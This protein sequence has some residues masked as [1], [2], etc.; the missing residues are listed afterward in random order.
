MSTRRMIEGEDL[1][2][3]SAANA[4][5]SRLAD[6]FASLREILRRRYL[7]MLAVTAI[8]F[9]LAIA[10]LLQLTPQYVAVAKLRID[11]SRN[12]VG[13]AREA[14]SGLS[15]EAIETEVT[16]LASPEIAREVTKRLGLVDDPA[17]RPKVKDG[18]PAPYG[19]QLLNLVSSDV[20]RGLDVR[21]EKLTYVIAVGYQAKD[22]TTAARIANAFAQTY[23]DTR[24]GGNTSTAQRQVEWFNKQIETLGA[25]ARGADAQ[26]AQY[27][28]QAGIVQGGA[29]GTITDQQVAPLSS[30]LAE[31]QSSAAEARAKLV[32]A[33]RQVRSGGLDAVADVRVS[34]VIADLRRQLAEVTRN[35]G[36]ITSRYGDRHPET[37]KV[38]QQVA[39]LNSQIQDEANRTLSSL[40][41]E[42]DAA[43]AR[44]A[45]LQSSLGSLK[46]QQAVN[47]RAA[48]IAEGME[49]E[50]A[51]KHT[52]YDKM[53]QMRLEALQASRNNIGNA[54]L[55]DSATPPRYPSAP[56]KRVLAALALVAALGMGIAVIAAQELLTSGMRTID[57]LESRLKLPVLG[58]LPRLA[59]RRGRGSPADTLITQ[60][61][62]LYGEALR[63][64]RASVLGVQ[65]AG[66]SRVV[67]FTSALP[68]EGKSTTALSF[69]RVLALGGTRTLLVD[70][71][72][73]RA[74]LLDMAG[75]TVSTGLVEVLRSQ[76]R[77][78]DAIVSDKVPQLDLLLV[79][80]RLF[81]AED[82]FGRDQMASLLAELRRTYDVIVLDLPPVMGVADARTLSV[83]ADVAILIV[84]WGKTPARAASTAL[85]WLRGDGAK[86][87]GAIYTMVDPASEA[88]GGL[89]YSSKYASYYQKD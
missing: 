83:M 35:L 30:Q 87:P 15:D 69:A 5:R 31:A 53:A 43:G 11:P 81:S 89:F 60:P 24:V 54:E 2:P 10:L 7:T 78:A 23:I 62:S 37:I 8:I 38:R 16:V 59:K 70:C 57:E 88:V 12:P 18:Q 20:A 40:R 32:Q 44:S 75:A 86:V 55:I 25:E 26:L 47:T 48:V 19:D 46:G 82:L 1:I 42:A 74:A 50:A 34:P 52:A 29:N 63:N 36:E 84:R 14:T 49:R 51:N 3:I 6:S 61:A 73:R 28:A 77:A 65:V 41:A 39:A 13:N 9:G 76:S 4:D 79:H 27:R 67:A 17:F 22:A 64:T 66:V 33:E 21:R 80:E 45:S 72:L 58:S 85:S 56:N 71:D 68:E